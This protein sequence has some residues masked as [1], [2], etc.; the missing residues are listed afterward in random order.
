MATWRDGTSTGRTGRNLENRWINTINVTDSTYGALGDDVDD[1]AAI[2]AAVAALTAGDTLYFPPGK[3]RYTTVSPA[4]GAAIYLNAV[5]NVTIWFA[6][7]AELLMDNLSGGEGT[8]HGVFIKGACENVRLVNVRVRWRTAPSSRSTGDGFRVTG[9]PKESGVTA[10]WTGTTGTCA[11]VALINCEAIDCPQ[12]GAIFMGCDRP[13]VSNLF[14]KDSL[15]DGLHFNACRNPRVT[16]YTGEN[17]GDD[18]LALVTYYGATDAPTSDI[19]SAQNGPFSLNT[20]NEWSNGSAQASGVTVRS[21]GANGVRLAGLY[22]G[23]VSGVS[24]TDKSVGIIIDGG[25]ADGGTFAWTYLASR[26]C[27]VTGAAIE[28][29]G[30]GVLA[31]VFVSDSADDEK[32]WRFDAVFSDI[33]IRNCSNRCIRTQGCGSGQNTVIAGLTF[34]GIRANGSNASFSSIRE[35]VIDGVAVRTGT[36]EFVGQDVV[37]SGAMST[38][39]RH[40]NIIDNI[41]CDGGAINFQDLR[42][43]NVGTVRSVNSDTSGVQ[44]TRVH[45]ASFGS[46][47][48]VLANRGNTGT[49][50]ALLL[51]KCQHVYIADLEIEHDDNTTTTWSSIEL[52]GGDATD[53]SNNI[54]INNAVYRNTINATDSDVTIQGGGNAPFD[55]IYRMRHYNGGEASPIWRNEEWGSTTWTDRFTYTG[56]PEGGITAKI[57]STYQRIDG[58]EDTAFYVKESGTGA[59]GCTAIPDA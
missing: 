39:A 21:G 57:G 19:Y 50:R 59:T 31:R 45:S 47:N 35:C 30:T 37:L 10:G 51:S 1:S 20:L 42:G 2:E 13:R 25:E 53:R 23:S 54:V 22:Q 4:N 9:Y 44:L 6:P 26:G 40:H 17:T 15:A 34:R 28:N 12:T 7:G 56:S 18:A 38:L 49:V 16:G 58:G 55:Y 14:V 32:Y 24:V 27:S 33:D 43:V 8:S 48:V 11:D 52:G 41:L 3:Y 46:I 29:C 36:V 5:S